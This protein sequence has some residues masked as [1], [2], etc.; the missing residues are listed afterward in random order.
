MEEEVA[1]KLGRSSLLQRAVSKEKNSSIA[2]KTGQMKW[3]KD[4][5]C[6]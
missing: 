3:E 2:F 1:E 6:C 5:E 4:R